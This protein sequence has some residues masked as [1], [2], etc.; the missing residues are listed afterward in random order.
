MRSI[1][2]LAFLPV[3]VCIV[4]ITYGQPYKWPYPKAKKDSVVDTYF[5]TTVSDPYRWLEDDSLPATRQWL[6]SQEELTKKWMFNL[7][8]KYDLKKEMGYARLWYGTANKSGKYFFDKMRVFHNAPACL[9]IKKNI[10]DDGKIVVDPLEYREGGSRSVEVVNYSPSKDGKYLAFSLMR[11]GSDW[12]E[13]RVTSIYPFK[14]Q[15]DVIKWV[16]FSPIV[17]RG[18]GFYY[19]RYDP[20][21]EGQVYK[22]KTVLPK[23]YY[24]TLGTNQ[25]EDSLVYQLNDTTSKVY[26]HSLDNERY[27]IIEKESHVNSKSRTMIQFWDFQEPNSQP[28]F[29]LSANV[30][31]GVFFNIV[32][33]VGEKFLVWT[34]SKAPNGKLQLFDPTMAN[35]QEDFIPQL[36]EVLHDVR[37]IGNKVMAVYLKDIDYRL[38]TFDKSGR[39]V[40]KLEYPHGCSLS[41]I[42]G[43]P[44]DSSALFYCHSFIVPPIAYHFN[45]NSFKLKAVEESVVSHNPAQFQMEKVYFTSKDGTKVPMIVAYKNGLKKN[46]KNPTLLYGYGGYGISYTPFFSNDFIFFMQNGGVIA[47]PC[48]RG[49]G[50]MGR[51]WHEDGALLKKQNVFNDFIG[52]AEY[53]ATEKYTNPEKLAIMGGSNGGLLVGAVINQRPDICQVAIAEVG[54]FDMLRY[55]KFTI[56]NAWSSEYGT[57]EDSVHFR[58]LYGYSPLHNVKNSTKYPAVLVVTGDHDDR[59]VPLHSYKFV[60]TLQEK[61]KGEAPILLYKGVNQGH[62]VGGES[63]DAFTFSFI[64]HNMG[65][66]PLGIKF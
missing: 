42:D 65:I 27:L 40:H 32:G 30:E 11:N 39:L 51:K 59:V 52:A 29:L 5:G 31:I 49:G 4:G 34:N 22:A 46:G 7:D 63:L 53:L 1:S 14:K 44:S 36:Q 3:L 62:Y 2:F 15:P 43:E 55:H 66:D 16:K 17:W 10:Y 28:R 25:E 23:I 37:V 18:N 33:K 45:V 54:A 56:G 64:Y 50:E 61:S 58:N 60:A 19:K 41:G 13:I 12:R 24:H 21:Q 48:L 6:A 8:M 35:K 47:L 57:S 20:P 9:F 38:Y 26:F